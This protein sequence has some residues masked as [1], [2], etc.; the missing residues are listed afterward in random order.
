[1]A[2]EDRGFHV[3]LATFA[4]EAEAVAFSEKQWEPE[5]GEDASDE[6]YKAWEDRNPS[7]PMRAELG[8]TYLDG[9][10]VETIWRADGESSGVNWHYLASLLAPDDVAKC[11]GQ[12]PHGSNTLIIIHTGALGGFDF[13]FRSTPTM[14]YCGCFRGRGQS[15]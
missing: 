12:A 3:F 10:F 13:A 8:F 7:W 4:S 1:M 2:A 6:E 11:R 15:A 9:D 14:T 5:P